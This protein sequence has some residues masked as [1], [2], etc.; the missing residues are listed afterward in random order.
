MQAVII[1]TADNE[2]LWPLTESTPSPL[3]SIGNRPV[4][5]IVLEQLARSGFKKIVICLHRMAGNIELYFGN[6][7]RWGV[8][9]EYVLTREAW[10]S[11]GALGWAKSLITE[12][13]IVMPADAILDLDINAALQ[14]HHQ[15]Q[16]SATV[17]LHKNKHQVERQVTP[18]QDDNQEGSPVEIKSEEWCSETGVYIFESETLNLIPAKKKFDIG[19]HFLPA[20]STAGLRVGVF[21]TEGYWNP[22]DSFCEFQDAQRTLLYSLWQDG[23]LQGE[24]FLSNYS[25]LLGKEVSTGVWVGRNTVIHTSARLVPPLILGEETRIGRGVILGPEVVVGASTIIAD[26]ASIHSST[27]F[28][29]TYVGQLVHIEDRL[30]DRALVVDTASSEHIHIS[31]QFLLNETPRSIPVIFLKRSLDVALASLFLLLTIPLTLSICLFSWISFGKV[32][33]RV[34]RMEVITR[35]LAANEPSQEVYYLLRFRTRSET[36]RTTWFSRWLERLEWNR[37]PELL[38]VLNGSMKLIG[39]KPLESDET[40]ELTAVWQPNYY[41]HVPGFTGLWYIQTDPYDGLDETIIANVYYKATQSFKQDMRILLKTPR[42]WF[43][44]VKNRG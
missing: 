18:E 15:N 13:F 23:P 29:H 25:Q 2:K 35:Q 32:F 39:T 10:G 37:L 17:I 21:V 3:L 31:D 43:T 7:S 4:M 33:Q 6:G 20:L 44:H 38:N 40:S 11:A 28:D 34:P 14:H 41:D 9:L 36:G 30:V 26:R 1:A 5:E 16:Y 8:S 22:L 24:K 12:P 27:I 19:V 42:V